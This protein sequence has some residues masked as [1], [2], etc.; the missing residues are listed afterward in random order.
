MGGRPP[1]GKD[2]VNAQGGFVRRIQR[3]HNAIRG[4]GA[5]GFFA[6]AVVL[7]I[8][9]YWIVKMLIVM[10][11]VL[12][13]HFPP[14]KV[15][16]GIALALLVLLAVEGARYGRKLFD[17]AAA[18]RSVYFRGP[19]GT[20]TENALSFVM[21]RLLGMAWLISQVLFSAPRS[22]AHAVRCVASLV[23]FREG[24]LA[25]AEQVFLDLARK[26]AWV[27][28]SEHEAN[29]AV[30]AKLHKLGAVSHRLSSSVPEVRVVP[31]V[32]RI[33]GLA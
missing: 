26:R 15:T 11:C 13:G 22:T 7:W 9:S 21:H 23:L 14:A 16:T 31:S 29:R 10:P 30:L 8:V 20:E 25:K 18:A 5:V 24:Q 2:A 6:L 27:P 3:R 4:A 33:C 12:W 1:N 19:T 32:L 17:V 28:L